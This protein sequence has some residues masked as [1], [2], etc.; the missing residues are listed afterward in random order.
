MGKSKVNLTELLPISNLDR[1]EYKYIQDLTWVTQHLGLNIKDGA[2]WE[3]VLSYILSID[4]LEFERRGHEVVF[5]LTP[6]PAFT[7]VWGKEDATVQLI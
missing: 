6:E 7:D 3:E 1:A 4:V 2:T 5:L